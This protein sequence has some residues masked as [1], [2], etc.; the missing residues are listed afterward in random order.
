MTY[1]ELTEYIRHYLENDKTKSAIMLSGEW[2]T[3]KSHFVQNVLIPELVKDGDSRCVVVSLYGLQ[4]IPEISK[5][6][7]LEMRAKA[8]QPRGEAT[9]TG[10]VVAKT[11]VK[12]I[13]SFL[14]ID[15]SLSETDIKIFVFR[16]CSRK[17]R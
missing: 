7:Y 14:G 5:S 11:V 12:G 3:G 2:G 17:Q 4:A 6:I 1:S 10:E 15:L 9:A 13:T 8:L 16:R